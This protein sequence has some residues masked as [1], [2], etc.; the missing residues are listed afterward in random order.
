MVRPPGLRRVS[1]PTTPTNAN[2]P[3]HPT[4]R[5]KAIISYRNYSAPAENDDP[6]GRRLPGAYDNEQRRHTD[7]PPCAVQLAYR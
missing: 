5:Q 7:Q 4:A 3:S 2:F 6:T 1:H